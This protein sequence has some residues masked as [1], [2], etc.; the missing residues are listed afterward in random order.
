MPRSLTSSAV[1]TI[2]CA[3]VAALSLWAYA[4]FVPVDRSEQ[5]AATVLARTGPRGAAAYRAAWS[6]GRLSP[7]DMRALREAAGR[8]IDSWNLASGN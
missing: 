7:G 1:T 4:E 3:S 8:D 6:D 2:T 5:H